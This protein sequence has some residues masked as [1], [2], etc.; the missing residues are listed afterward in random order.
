MGLCG[1]QNAATFN[2][3]RSS[4]ALGHVLITSCICYAA[5]ITA[6]PLKEEVLTLAYKVLCL[7]N[8]KYQLKGGITAF[9]GTQSVRGV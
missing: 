4:V 1:G 5:H 3:G 2:M 9:H 6:F 8:A 7:E